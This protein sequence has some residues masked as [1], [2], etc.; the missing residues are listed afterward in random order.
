MG[1]NL[2][3]LDRQRNLNYPILGSRSLQMSFTEAGHGPGSRRFTLTGPIVSVPKL[4]GMGPAP[5][6]WIRNFGA[7]PG[8]PHVR[9]RNP[10]GRG[11]KSRI[12]YFVA[13][14]RAQQFRAKTSEPRP[15]SRKV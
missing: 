7:R 4:W 1:L 11:L 12:R 6:F 3:R 9:I 14:A 13:R 2:I 5:K 8:S 15:P 10:N